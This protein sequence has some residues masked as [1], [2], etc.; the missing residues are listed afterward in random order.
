VTVV[1]NTE[2]AVRFGRDREGRGW[3]RSIS[4]RV[5]EVAE[6]A[7]PREWERPLGEDRGFLWRLNSYWRYEPVTGGVLVE[8]ESISLSRSAPALVRGAVQP[9]IDSVARGSMERTLL[10]MRARLRRASVD[11]EEP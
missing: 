7:T 11:G 10:V 2:H 4:T 1:Y 3:S 8:C 9:L 5:A 6:P